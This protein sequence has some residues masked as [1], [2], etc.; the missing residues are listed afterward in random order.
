MS[1]R[2]KP[3]NPRT[4]RQQ[5]NRMDFKGMVKKWQKLPAGSKARWNEPV[6]DRLL[7]GYNEFISVNMKRN[8]AGL[9][10]L[11]EGPEEITGTE[12]RRAAV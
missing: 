1:Y 6:G 11:L 3:K 12:E 2:G 8:K 7:S 10:L 9:P 4:P 5:E